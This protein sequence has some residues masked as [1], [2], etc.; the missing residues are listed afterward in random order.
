MFYRDLLAERHRFTSVQTQWVST[1]M[2]VK[3]P[4]S[5]LVTPRIEDFARGRNFLELNQARQEQSRALPDG[6]FFLP[7]RKS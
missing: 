2:F 5:D 1:F 3:F 4:G 6:I 7:G